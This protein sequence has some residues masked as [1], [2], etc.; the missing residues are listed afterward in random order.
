ML[1]RNSEESLF[2]DGLMNMPIMGDDSVPDRKKVTP[3]NQAVNSTNTSANDTVSAQDKLSLYGRWVEEGRF[4]GQVPEVLVAE[5]YTSGNSDFDLLVDSIVN[6]ISGLVIGSVS[7]GVFKSKYKKIRSLNPLYRNFKT[8]A[9]AGTELGLIFYN[10]RYLPMVLSTAIFSLAMGLFAIPYWLYREYYSKT[11]LEQ[12][13][14]YTRVGPEGW[15][16]YAKTFLVFGMYVGEVIG[17]FISFIT[18]GDFLRNIAV[19]GAIGSF[20]AFIAGLIAVPLIN[21][22]YNNKLIGTKDAFRNNYVRSGITFGVALGS[23]IGFVIGTVA[24]PGLGSL[25]GMAMGA[26]F[27]S[28]IGG[29]ALGVYGKKITNY[30]Q[31]KWKVKENT[32]NSWDYATRNLSYLFGFIGA[33]IG[34][35]VPVPGGA[36]MGA[37]LGTA[38]GGAV[39]WAAGFFVIRAARK[40][41]ATENIAL[42]LPWTQRIA[43]GTM[44][45]SIVGAGLGFLIGLAGGPAGAVLGASLGYSLGATLGGLSYGLYDKSARKLLRHYFTGKTIPADEEPLLT[46]ADL[47]DKTKTAVSTA[48][49]FPVSVA[50]V[51][52]ISIATSAP[53]KIETPRSGPE[54]KEP[55]IASQPSSSPRITSLLLAKQNIA[56]S[57]K[58]QPPRLL[59]RGKSLTVDTT[60]HVTLVHGSEEP[61]PNKFEISPLQAASHTVLFKPHAGRRS[62][63]NEIPEFTLSAITL[64]A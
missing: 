24:F 3:A 18:R 15:S 10:L 30:L 9:T 59:L 52:Q 19:Y 37:T 35:F 41:S 43:N 2:Q 38:V 55:L 6:K 12:R 58:R 20:V 54:L 61:I 4:I 26:A 40:T 56:S 27:G 31:R 64:E 1:S 47:E 14:V 29:I 21:K 33:A 17:N 45:G 25:A 36:L 23:V 13:N 22:F 44:L 62:P 63:I 7:H 46:Y 49:V 39:G 32:D 34:F 48:S 57:P 42:T 51:F 8:L 60:N 50:P 28:V 16:K 11:P 5:E 53:E